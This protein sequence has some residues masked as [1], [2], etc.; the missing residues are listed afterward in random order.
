MP[1]AGFIVARISFLVITA[2]MLGVAMLAAPAAGQASTCSSSSKCFF[3]VSVSPGPGATPPSNPA[4]GTNTSFTFT[5]QNEASPQQ[6]GAVQ[7]SAPTGFMITGASVASGASGTAS[8]TSSSALFLNLSLA[9]GSQTMLT[10]K[11]TVPC[12]SGSYQWGIAAKQSNNFNGSGND[13]QLDP[14]FAGNLS[15]KFTGS[16][17]FQ[18][19]PPGTPC[20]ASASSATTSGT[21]TTSSALPPGDSIVTG[22]ESGS[23]N[24]SFNFSC[25]TTPPVYTPLS[26]VFGFAVFNA[27]GVP[28]PIT[29]TVTLRIDK[30]LVNSSGHPGASSW[31]ICYAS[32]TSFNALPGTS[33]QNV[34][35]GGNP[36]YFTGLL[37]D[38]SSTHGAP[39]CVQARNKNNAGDVIV[40]FLAL[41][42]PYGHG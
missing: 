32:T 5:I 38:C 42:D 1:K 18:P 16:C 26:D 14:R 10:V 35:I 7:I 30:S 17:T 39:P 22:M 4:V 36:G 28:Q 6:L 12:G 41:G 31:Q 9:S 24:S 27:S 21:V 19:C 15:G 11:A 29:L 37:P 40:T 8:F 3:A 2:S 34:T 23:V 25:G 20:S 13:F 33:Q